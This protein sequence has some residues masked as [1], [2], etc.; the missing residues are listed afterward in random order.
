MIRFL[1][2]LAADIFGWRTARA[3]LS[4]AGKCGS[5]SKVGQHF[6]TD[7]CL[8][9]H[10]TWPNKSPEPTPVTPALLSRSRRLADVISPAWLSFLR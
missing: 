1:V 5:L 8:Q 4:A 9:I 2:S 3:D 6:M 10:A 7:I